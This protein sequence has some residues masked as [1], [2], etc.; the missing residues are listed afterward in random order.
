MHIDILNN[1]QKELFSKLSLLLN[2][3][4]YLAGGTALALQLGHRTSLDLDF[5][6]KKHFEAG[7]LYEKIKENF[8]G[9][10]EKT[11][12]AKDTLFCKANNIDI[13][14]FWYK[15]PL[16]RKTAN[17]LGVQLAS[18]EDIAAMK[19]VAVSRRPAKRDYIDI[20]FL[21][22]KFSLG[23]IFS[24]TKEKYPDI[25]HYFSLRALT[26]FEDIK[27]EE[28]RK[29]K[30]LDKNFSWEEAKEKIFEEVKKHQ[31]EMLKKSR[32]FNPA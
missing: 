7:D 22:K 19:L 30:V 20:F 11:S 27:D 32:G 10:I 25:N 13:S 8:S 23:E 12:Q 14:F 5:F 24:F 2:K 28:K 21:L 15:H 29:I 16:I 6:T 26:Y 17:I 3:E 9:S 31:L 4:F 18:L 1:D